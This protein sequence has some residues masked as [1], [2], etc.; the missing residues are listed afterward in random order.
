MNNVLLCGLNVSIVHHRFVTS[1]YCESSCNGRLIMADS[2][3][4]RNVQLSRLRQR[5]KQKQESLADQFDFKMYIIFNFKEKK[6]AAIYEVSEVITVMTN[7]YED[8][9]LREAKEDAYSLESSR[10]LLDKDIIQLHSS[11]W[12]SLRKDVLGVTTD[13]DFF[14]WPR[15]DIDQ[16]EC[17]IFSR[18]KGDL[19]PFKMLQATF[20]FGR[21]D[22]EKQLTCLAGR[23]N[24]NGLIL[25][26]PDQNL[27]LFV[28]RYN[29]QTKNNRGTM[30]YKLSSLCVYL[31][32]DMLLAWAP[33]SL[34]DVIKK[35]QVL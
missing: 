8:C 15:Q 31:P 7:N 27:F 6:P 20:Q 16:I 17:L 24:K 11:K 13:I 14:L 22:C 19:E 2:L 1:L 33:G 21:E 4:R 5:L 35:Y 3:A 32:Q 29:I 23:H 12:H 26:N 25:H 28:D 18:W 30:I 10:K 9:I 34:D